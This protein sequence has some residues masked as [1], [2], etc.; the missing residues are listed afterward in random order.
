MTFAHLAEWDMG[1][2]QADMCGSNNGN[3]RSSV[4][5]A[6]DF[7]IHIFPLLGEEGQ[8]LLQPGLGSRI[9]WGSCLRHALRYFFFYFLHL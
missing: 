1:A 5:I 4:D 8:D 6:T 2:S 7:G 3:A 9:Q